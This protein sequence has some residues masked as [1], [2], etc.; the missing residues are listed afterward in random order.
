MHVRA[1]FCTA[2]VLAAVSSLSAGAALG[3]QVWMVH[4]G[5]TR[6]MLNEARLAE[7]GLT[8][9]VVRGDSTRVPQGTHELA[10][11]DRSSFVVHSEGFH[12]DAFAGGQIEHDSGLW[13]AY[14]GE[15]VELPR[16]SLRHVTAPDFEGL[17]ATNGRG[18]G[19]AALLRFVEGKSGF[20]V[21][22][23]GF[24]AEATRV[25]ITETLAALLG[26][27]SLAGESIGEVFVA[28]S[29]H[30]V[31]G[32]P[33]HDFFPAPEDDSALRVCPNPTVGP[34]MV[35]GSLS[36]VCNHAAQEIPAGSGNWYDAISVGVTSCNLGD[37]VVLWAG[38][39][40]NHP[41]IGQSMYRLKDGRFEMIGQSWL[42]NAGVAVSGTF[43]CSCNGGGGLGPGCSDPYGCGLNS[44]QGGASSKSEVNAFT[45]DFTWPIGFNPPWSGTVA[46]RVAIPGRYL[47]P[48]QNV[49]AT[50]FVG[51]HVIARD[52][53]AAGNGRNN[54][55]WAT[56][57]VTAAGNEY[58]V[59]QPGPTHM[60]IPPIYAWADSDPSV[61]IVSVVVPNEGEYI[62][63]TKVTDLGTG[64]WRYEYAVANNNSDRSAGSFSVPITGGATVTNIGFHDVEYHSGDPYA[65][66]DW[67]GVRVAEAIQWDVPDAANPMANAIRWG[68]IYNFRFDANVPPDPAPADVYIGLFKS[69]APAGVHASVT[70]PQQGPTDC[71]MDG[72]P[73]ICAISCQA[74]ELDV[75]CADYPDCGTRLDCNSD[76]VPDDCQDDCNGNGIPDDCDISD[77][78]SADVNGDGLP[79]ECETIR[80]MAGAAPGGSGVSWDA[81]MASLSEAL[82]LAKQFQGRIREIW[83]GQGVYRPDTAG[84]GSP[85]TAS[86]RLVDG[87]GVYGGFAGT[88]TDRDQRDPKLNLSILSGD[89][90][91]NDG[92][93]FGGHGENSYHV[94]LASSV[95]PGTV[96]D[97]FTITGGNTVGAAL[98]DFNGGGVFVLNGS[99]S[100]RNLTITRNKAA[101][102]GGVYMTGSPESEM[103]NCRVFGNQATS[104]GGGLALAQSNPMLVNTTIAGNVAGNG[105]AVFSNA[106]SPRFVNSTIVANH[107]S[108]LGGG[109]RL[110]GA[111]SSLMFDNCILWLNTSGAAQTA[112]QAAQVS[113]AGG[114]I[115]LQFRHSLVQGWN[116][117]LSGDATSGDDP[118]LVSLPNHGGDGWGT[119]GNDQFG[120]LRLTANSPAVDM[121]DSSLL[122]AGV[123]SDIDGLDRIVG[124]EVDA[125]AHERQASTVTSGACC[126]SGSCAEVAEAAACTVFVCDVFTNEL[127]ECGGAC[128]T[129]CYGDVNGD[130]VVTAADRGFISAAIGQS[131][132]AQLCQ[133]DA[134][135]NGFINAGDRGFVAAAIGLCL[136]LPDWQNGSGLGAD[137]QPDTRFGTATFMG[138]GSTCGEVVCP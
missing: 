1:P 93:D 111:G 62:I 129:T 113:I 48:A 45:G 54:Q 47:D 105:G 8:V 35:P 23:R 32:D 94:V 130:G 58:T 71:D 66:S 42:K 15:V 2:L 74:V 25:E 39:T 46:R 60:G 41:L 20:D 27:E 115:T 49:G 51:G 67:P 101:W 134:D 36:G 43:C 85:R 119:G 55:S 131:A 18:D 92:P 123:T 11:I 86:F 33:E 59:S 13:I 37:T 114:G 117:T 26:N 22:D 63:G 95:G 29:S 132:A 78:T 19:E 57:T 133:Y 125:G 44:V 109:I 87:V 21:V 40:P 118:L 138:A 30:W 76:S 120:D 81:P 53:G 122:P 83:V 14:S 4:G 6:L 127:P 34:D 73:D 80:V 9:T 97:G 65:G 100:L 56:V 16:F 98:P 72:L 77:T 116:G 10:V 128:G 79:D 82:E 88:E 107:A 75:I 61:E 24:L 91:D 50:Y 7:L 136:D 121:G 110:A 126:T 38:G 64:M 31:A 17:V 69:G 90:G 3:H 108:S 99:V 5:E 135:G 106:A 68:T 103:V 112:D 84:L 89:L 52:D 96:L 124:D 104:V 28:A 70:V 102:G 12:L 137:G